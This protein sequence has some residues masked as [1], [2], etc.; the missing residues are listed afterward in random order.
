[1]LTYLSVSFCNMDINNK[2][3][4]NCIHYIILLE[5]ISLLNQISEYPAHVEMNILKYYVI[6]LEYWYVFHA[7]ECQYKIVIVHLFCYCL[8]RSKAFYFVNIVLKIER[9]VSVRR[10]FDSR[11]VRGEGK[12]DIFINWGNH[13]MSRERA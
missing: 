5:T 7:K 3:K 6:K 1:M 4:S 10:Y 13:Y 2:I 11:K 8:N 9:P 12:S